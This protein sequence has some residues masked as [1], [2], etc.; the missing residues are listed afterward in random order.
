[1][2]GL[3][4]REGC[5]RAGSEGGGLAGLVVRRGVAGLVVREGCGRAGSEGGGFVALQRHPHLLL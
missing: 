2:A 1:M 3:V 4:V 5:G